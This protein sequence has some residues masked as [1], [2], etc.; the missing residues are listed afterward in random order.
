[1]KIVIAGG[2]G[3][4]GR[5]LAEA[6]AEDGHDVRVLTRSLPA[7]ESR[8]DTGT[9]TPGITRVGWH[10]DP[11]GS[12]EGLRYGSHTGTAAAGSPEALRYGSQVWA[13]V[14]D[15]AN[16]VIN[17]A[18]ESIGDQRWTPERKA[19]LRNSRIGPTRAL[20]RVIASA[21]KP[22]RVLISASGVGYYGAAGDE[23]KTEDSPAGTDFLS[24]L[25]EDWEAEA[26]SAATSGTRVVL[27]RTGVVIERSGG[28]LAKM[29]PAFRLFAG[30]PMGSGRQYMSWIHR[31]DYLEMVR[32]IVD[33]PA[34]EGPVNATAPHP[35]TNQAF[36]RALGR[37]LKRPSLIPAPA[38]ALK[39]FLGE[40]AGPLV[41]SGQRVLPTR[42]Q[43]HGYD[44]RYPEIDLA[45]RGIFGEP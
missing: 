4:L 9:G 20:A 38:F 18:G 43:A 2:T 29:I 41:L 16:A 24:K 25:C 6:Y 28:A 11:A 26:R 30:G 15:D 45:M 19:Q 17:L 33:T 35:V 7:G 13:E 31:H 14:V 23:P 44:F 34:V 42:A 37:A 12:P 40:M 22:P 1:M 27:L 21:A 39:I 36:A 3:F 8:H 10:P 5:P 32:W